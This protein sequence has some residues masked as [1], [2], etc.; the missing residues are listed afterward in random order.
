MDIFL[1]QLLNI[2][3][4]YNDEDTVSHRICHTGYRQRHDGSIDPENIEQFSFW[5]QVLKTM[6]N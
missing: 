3:R 5:R 2:Q 1:G 4:D 6:L